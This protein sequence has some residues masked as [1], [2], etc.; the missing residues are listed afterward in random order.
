[1][2]GIDLTVDRFKLQA[3]GKGIRMP[4]WV[5][6]PIVEQMIKD[7]ES[8]KMDWD[9]LDR[10]MRGYPNSSY[11]PPQPGKIYGRRAPFNTIQHYIGN[12]TKQRKS[13]GTR[14]VGNRGSKMPTRGR[15]SGCHTHIVLVDNPVDKNWPLYIG[16]HI[17]TEWP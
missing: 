9:D 8:G 16:K 10:E 14:R 11:C 5:D 2:P 7:L 4:N 12:P 17:I 15:C 13:S 3:L 1:M 6:K